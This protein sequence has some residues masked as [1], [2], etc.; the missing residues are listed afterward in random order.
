MNSRGVAT[1]DHMILTCNYFGQLLDRR[2]VS[3][4]RIV[5]P[6]GVDPTIVYDRREVVDTTEPTVC[7]IGGARNI[8]G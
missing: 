2:G 6:N 3:V 7:Y 4:E 1:V 5:I 8:K